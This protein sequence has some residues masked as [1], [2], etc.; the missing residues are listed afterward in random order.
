MDLREIENVNPWKH[1]YYLAKASAVKELLDPGSSGLLEVIDVGA[2]SAFFSQYLSDFFPQSRFTC[3]DPNYGKPVEKITERITLIQKYE[4]QNADLFMFMDVL[5]HVQSDLSLLRDYI[6]ESKV[7]TRVL[8][9][10]PAFM[11][12]WSQHDVYLGH[13]RRYTKKEVIALAQ[14]AGL[15]VENSYYL[16]STLLPLLF[17]VRKFGYRKTKGSNMAEVPK[18]LNWLLLKIHLIEHKFVKNPFFGLSIALLAVKS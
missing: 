8:I 13:Y 10:V 3:I 1:W 16:F 9:T 11:T 5:E 14:A 4:G 6:D 15:H 18:F 7:G 2:G 17:L 12:L